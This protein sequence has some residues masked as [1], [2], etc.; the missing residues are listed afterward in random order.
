M[1]PITLPR[2]TLE[3]DIRGT[4]TNGHAFLAGFNFQVP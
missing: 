2:G 4:D 3:L 1:H